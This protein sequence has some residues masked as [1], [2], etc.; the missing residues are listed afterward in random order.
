[1]AYGLVRVDAIPGNT[2]QMQNFVKGVGQNFRKLEESLGDG[3][4]DTKTWTDGDGATHTVTLV[5]GLITA[6]TIV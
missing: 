1:M 6:W 2:P 4:S 5:D 3:L